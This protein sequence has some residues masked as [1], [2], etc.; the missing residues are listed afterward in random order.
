MPLSNCY[1]ST[2]TSCNILIPNGYFSELVFPWP[3]YGGRGDLPRFQSPSAKLILFK[4]PVPGIQIVSLHCLGHTGY[5]TQLTFPPETVR[6]YAEAIHEGA[7]EVLSFSETE[8]TF[9]ALE[10]D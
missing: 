7:A 10:K 8:D 2:G 9:C 1:C 5:P 6:W 4:L 3:I